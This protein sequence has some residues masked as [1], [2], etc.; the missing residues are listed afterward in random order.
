MGHD[1]GRGLGQNP[2]VELYF[3]CNQSVYVN[4]TG[5]YPVHQTDTKG[6]VRYYGLHTRCC[7]VR[8]AWWACRGW[9]P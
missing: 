1:V 4:S 9:Q 3:T 5:D 8:G 6:A 7:E 2:D